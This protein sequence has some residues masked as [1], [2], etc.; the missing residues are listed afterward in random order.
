METFENCTE[1]VVYNFFKKGTGNGVVKIT[2]YN[3]T[4]IGEI[5]APIGEP[6]IC[7]CNKS[8]CKHS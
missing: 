8:H 3:N 2:A 1:N 6:R 5:L 7:F 4:I